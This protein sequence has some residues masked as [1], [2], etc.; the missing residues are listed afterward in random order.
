M[1]GPVLNERRVS[2]QSL[3]T[4]A[5]TDGQ[6]I[7]VDDL[8]TAATKQNMLSLKVSFNQPSFDFCFCFNAVLSTTI[9]KYAG[10]L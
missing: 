2:E 7:H 6:G 1:P 9:D 3:A 10:H 4:C 5:K 8:G